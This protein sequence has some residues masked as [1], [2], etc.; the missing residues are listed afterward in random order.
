MP[1]HVHGNT[2]S[3]G[4]FR[5]ASFCR[6]IGIA[7]VMIM[8]DGEA[9]AAPVFMQVYISFR[10]FVSFWCDLGCHSH[11]LGAREHTTAGSWGLGDKNEKNGMGYHQSNNNKK[12]IESVPGF[13]FIYCIEEETRRGQKWAVP[14]AA[15][16]FKRL[17]VE[18]CRETEAHALPTRT[19]HTTAAGTHS[20]PCHRPNRSI[21]PSIDWDRRELNCA[22]AFRIAAGRS[23]RCCVFRSIGRSVGAGRA[24]LLLLI[25]A[26]ALITIA[27]PM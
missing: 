3:K 7:R 18:N 16:K 24:L 23:I 27:P 5:V 15:T 1:V 10:G 2:L 9:L 22:R 25:I 26:H 17:A 8:A 6:L 21:D 19:Q 4:F 11:K 14:R 20:Q 13:A 12:G